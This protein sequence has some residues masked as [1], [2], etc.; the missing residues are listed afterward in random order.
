[1]ISNEESTIEVMLNGGTGVG[2][3]LTALDGLTA[4]LEH[5]RE[6]KTPLRDLLAQM[7]QRGR[8]STEVTQ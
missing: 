5:V 1:M 8:E 4:E 3:L 7:Y 6:L 2:Q